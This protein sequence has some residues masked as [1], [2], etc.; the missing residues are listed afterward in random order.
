MSAELHQLREQCD[1][2]DVLADALRTSDSWLSYRALA[3]RDQL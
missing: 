2:F 3:L 1:A